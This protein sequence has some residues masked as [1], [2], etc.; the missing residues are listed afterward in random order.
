M[1]PLSIIL[2]GLYIRRARASSPSLCPYSMHRGYVSQYHACW[3]AT[4][5]KCSLDPTT[6]RQCNMDAS[7]AGVMALYIPL[8]VD[9]DPSCPGRGR[10]PLSRRHRHGSGTLQS[11]Q[12]STKEP[13][14]SSRKRFMS[15]SDALQALHRRPARAPA[16]SLRPFRQLRAR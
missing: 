6:L 10:V 4:R 2:V 7:V 16:T 14:V 15:T 13:F 12:S 1:T 11:V 9:W 8:L 3:L 5:C